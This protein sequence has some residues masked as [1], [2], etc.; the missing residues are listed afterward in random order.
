M[1]RSKCVITLQNSYTQI[2]LI[3]IQTELGKYFSLSLSLSLFSASSFLHTFRNG[4]IILRIYYVAVSPVIPLPDR[5]YS[6]AI[7]RRRPH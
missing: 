6:A 4:F 1:H 7:V 2:L 3:N 5:C